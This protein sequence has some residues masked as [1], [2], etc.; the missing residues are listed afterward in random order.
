MTKSIIKHAIT[1]SSFKVLKILI[2]IIKYVIAS[3]YVLTMLK[4]ITKSS[5]FKA[6]TMLTYLNT[7]NT[8]SGY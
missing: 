6:P 4:S 7:S 1:S 3:S 2:S 8:N 5:S